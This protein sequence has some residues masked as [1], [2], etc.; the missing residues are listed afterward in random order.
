VPNKL[1]KKSFSCFDRL[2]TNEKSS[3]ISTPAPFALS[4]SKGE[5][6]VFQQPAKG[7]P[8]IFHLP[9]KRFLFSCAL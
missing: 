4:L 6:G 9:V 8:E 1:L 7:S 2:S 3:T 5:R